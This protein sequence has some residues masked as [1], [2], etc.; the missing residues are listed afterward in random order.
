MSIFLHPFAV[1]DFLFPVDMAASS[2]KA[3]A[4]PIPRDP[5]SSEASSQEVL[6]DSNIQPRR[7]S[8][9]SPRLPRL[10]SIKGPFQLVLGGV[11]TNPHRSHTRKTDFKLIERLPDIL[12]GQFRFHRPEGPTCRAL[13]LTAGP[14]STGAWRKVFT[15]IEYPRLVF[16]VMRATEDLTYTTEEIR[17][18]R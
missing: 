13:T 9:L 5:S 3:R 8:L 16:K 4:R 11:L 1:S 15:A 10:H 18:F 17:A 7:L 12:R 2:S 14:S 6:E